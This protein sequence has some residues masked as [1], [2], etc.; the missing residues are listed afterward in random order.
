MASPGR[1][2]SAKLFILG[3]M[4]SPM[5]ALVCAVPARPR[6]LDAAAHSARLIPIPDCQPTC[7]CG[8]CGRGGA[9]PCAQGSSS[10]SR[11]SACRRASLAACSRGR[12]E[13]RRRSRC[14]ARL[15]GRCGLWPSG[16]SC[17]RCGGR[18][19]PTPVGRESCSSRRARHCAG[20]TAK[21]RMWP[22]LV[23]IWCACVQCAAPTKQVRK[24][25]G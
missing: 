24:T 7:T 17:A 11:R 3:M 25:C 4:D 15:G 6:A 18:S 16:R 13:R 19:P 23:K 20:G 8:A 2:S 22:T 10:T 12:G 14:C 5:C 1:R 21:R 9:R